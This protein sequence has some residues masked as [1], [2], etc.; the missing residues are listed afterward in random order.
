MGEKMAAYRE[1]EPLGGFFSISP[2]EI[3][4]LGSVESEI[5]VIGQA[6]AL[7]AL[8]MGT[9]ISSKGYNV[10]VTG[11]PGTGR[12][13]AIRK[14]LSEYRPKRNSMKDIG[15]VYNYSDPDSPR[16]LYFSPGKAKRFKKDLHQLVET[17]KVLIKAKLEGDSYKLRRDEIVS[18][19][20]QQENRI[21]SEFETRLGKDNFQIIRVD[22]EEEG[23][24]ADII[25]IYKGKPVS[26]DDLQTRVAAGDI[27]EKLWNATREKYYHYIDEMQRIFHDLKVSRTVMEDQLSALRIETLKPDIHE[28]VQNLAK[29][30]KENKRAIAYLKDLED[31]IL[32]N[33]YIFQQDRQVVDEGGNPAL[34][35]YGVHIVVEQANLKKVPVIFENRPT[36]QN[37]FGTVET[38]FDRKRRV[39]N[40]FHDDK[41]RFD[42]EG[43]RRLP[44]PQG[45]GRTLRD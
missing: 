27:K 10:F 17:M 30:Y 38:R 34:I 36:Y 24:A 4:G 44:H 25:P 37:L 9:E 5:D 43:L 45:R 11:L 41:G 28:E 40:E 14:V 39:E 12:K 2:D 26:F 21:L 20:E 13:T 33:M 19:I 32:E 18:G 1:F 3:R 7:K 22:D 42:H 35:R 15:F 16:V 31:D 29:G 23:Q 8:R 6:R